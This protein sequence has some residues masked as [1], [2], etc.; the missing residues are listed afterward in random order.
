MLAPSIIYVL[1]S[2]LTFCSKFQKP[3]FNF[4]MHLCHG[5][6]WC[7]HS[8]DHMPISLLH[9]YVHFSNPYVCVLKNLYALTPSSIFIHIYRHIYMYACF[10][11]SILATYN[12]YVPLGI[13]PYISVRRRFAWC[14][15]T[16]DPMFK[17][18]YFNIH[19]YLYSMTIHTWHVHTHLL[20]FCVH[21]HFPSMRSSTP[22]WVFELTTST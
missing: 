8:L 17:G 3:M 2:R 13:R 5:P 14:K 7:T 22:F 20:N 16:C 10:N 18:L 21:L 19:T 15:H 4:N 11:Y 6:N 9:L 12:L 1:V